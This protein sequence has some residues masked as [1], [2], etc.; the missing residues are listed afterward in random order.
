ME[1]LPSA[2]LGIGEE[3]SDDS[4]K[5][6][7][8][9]TLPPFSSQYLEWQC[10]VNRPSVSEPVVVT[11]LID[12]G[13]HS[14]LIDEGLVAKLGL[15]RR[16]L[17][18]PQRVH[19]AMGEAEVIFSEWVKLP[20]YS[21]DQQWTAHVVQAVVALGLTYPVILGGP[22]L[23]SNKVVI[24]HKFGRVTAKDDRYQLLPE[25]QGEPGQIEAMSSTKVWPPA[26]VLL[27]LRERMKDWKDEQ[28]S[29]GSSYEHFAK[30]LEDRIFVLAV[31]NELA[32]YEQ[33]VWAE[34]E[35]RFPTDIPHVTRLPDD[36]Y[37]CFR[38]KDAE[39][40]I[41]S[42]SYACPKKYKDAWK[43]LL[44][45]HLVAGRIRESSSE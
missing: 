13:S 11:A 8:T 7:H 35:D 4:M 6:I 9:S 1:S 14:V 32:T 24:N 33:D 37:H 26:D 22:F 29:T 23:E 45:Q 36:V 12:N 2:V 44:D 43:Q 5:Y 31:W 3:D 25:P 34:F 20:L 16:R 18:S 42:Q 39:K 30:M 17:P 21:Y 41:K 10:R 28:S 15:R 38:L 27:E 19:L 40:V